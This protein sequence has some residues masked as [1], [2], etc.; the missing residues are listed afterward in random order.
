MTTLVVRCVAL[1]VPVDPGRIYDG[2]DPMYELWLTSVCDR[3][4]ALRRQA[5]DKMK[6]G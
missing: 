4:E 6:A 5:A 3:V 1:E 2:E